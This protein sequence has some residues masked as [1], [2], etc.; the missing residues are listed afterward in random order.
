MMNDVKTNVNKKLSE[1]LEKRSP[2]F[3]E[4]GGWRRAGFDNLRKNPELALA[5]DIFLIHSALE[6]NSKT[7]KLV[8]LEDEKRSEFMQI[9]TSAGFD[10][11]LINMEFC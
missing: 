5:V 7:V 4:N 1:E 6:K 11:S 10:N 8:A 2:I 9:L 3:S